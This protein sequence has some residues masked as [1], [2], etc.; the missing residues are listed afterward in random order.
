MQDDLKAPQRQSAGWRLFETLVSPATFSTPARYAIALALVGLALAV[1]LWLAPPEAGLPFITFFPAAAL[2]AIV[3]GLGPGLL[4]VFICSG[5]ATTLFMPPIFEPNFTLWSVI[6]YVLDGILVCGAIEAMRRYHAFYKQAAADLEEARLTSENA[7]RALRDSNAELEQ[8]AYIASHDLQEPLRM[9]VSYGQL[10]KRRYFDRLDGD[11]HDF[12]DFMVE[13]ATRMQQMVA[14]LLE[15]SRIDRDGEVPEWIDSGETIATVLASLAFATEAAHATVSVGKTPR[16]LFH[17]AQFIRLMQNLVSNA[18]KYRDPARPLEITIAARRDDRRWVFSVS[19][20]GIGIE[21][22]YFAR[23]FMIFQR[24][25]TRDKYE[26]SGIGL[27]ICKKIVERQGGSVWVQSQPDKGSTF[28][29]SVPITNAD[30]AASAPIEGAAK[31]AD[32]R[33][34]RGQT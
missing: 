6:V 15:Y 2:A 26:G 7:N 1:R 24:L 31:R 28:L 9:V 12:V 4:A 3:G 21:P 19:D 34:R 33:A 13:G 16:I 23:I 32:A 11:G 20:T 5:L 8:F 29:F 17:R 30:E 22:Q 10:L 27:A 18:T 14:E 25:H